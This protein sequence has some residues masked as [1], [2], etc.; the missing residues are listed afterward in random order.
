MNI[1]KVQNPRRNSQKQALDADNL[2]QLPEVAT[3]QYAYCC[4]MV[5][6]RVYYACEQSVRRLAYLAGFTP[7]APVASL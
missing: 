4:I 7:V 2:H 3:K 6:A 1:T 5:Y